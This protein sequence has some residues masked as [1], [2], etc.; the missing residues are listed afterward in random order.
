MEK[1]GFAIGQ[2][3]REAGSVREPGL[4]NSNNTRLEAGSSTDS[5]LPIEE[6]QRECT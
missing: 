3:Q 2:N 1:N 4:N 5:I 6:H